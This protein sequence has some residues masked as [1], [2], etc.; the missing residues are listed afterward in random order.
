MTSDCI[1]RQ[2][3]LDSFWK[4]DIELRP[5]AIDAIVSMINNLPPITPR[6][7]QGIGQE[8]QIKQDI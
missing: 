2:V 8:L 7:R 3:V 6:K 4:L 1:S 5:S